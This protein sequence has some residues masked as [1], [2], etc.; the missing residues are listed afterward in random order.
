MAVAVRGTR[1]RT[2]DGPISPAGTR[3]PRRASNSG[4]ATLTLAWSGRYNRRMDAADIATRVRE[5]LARLYGN[6]LRGVV[7]YGSMARGDD[8]S[9]SD[10]DMLVMLDGPVVWGEELRRIVHELYPL[11]LQLLRPIHAMPVDAASYEAGTYALFRNV[12]KEG[13]PA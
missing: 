11:Q 5:R 13:I 10:I 4:P 6:R 3:T 7:L 1:G 12:R 8:D 2:G 9:D